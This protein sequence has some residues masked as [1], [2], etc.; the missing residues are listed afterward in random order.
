MKRRLFWIL[1]VV[2]IFLAG[3]VIRVF[4]QS[5]GQT[6]YL[7]VIFKMGTWTPTFTMTPTKTFTPTMT[8]TPTFTLTPTFTSTPT[9][10]I[11]PSRTS[12]LTS[13]FTP[14]SSPTITKTAS[15][16][17]VTSPPLWS[18]TAYINTDGGQVIYNLGCEKG[19]V[20]KNTTGKQDS[21]VL[22]DF[23]S[24]ATNNLDYGT[25]LFGIGFLRTTEIAMRA[26][27][28][29]QGYYVCSGTDHTSQLTLAIGTTNYGTWLT[30][31]NNA[32]DHGRAWATMVNNI[33]TWLVQNGYAGQITVVGA[34][35]IELTW[36][37]PT[38][39]KAWVNGYD[40]TN[41]FDVYDY[42]DMAGCPSRD[43][44]TSV[45]AISMD[46]GR[47]SGMWPM[48]SRRLILYL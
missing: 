22:L 4:S 23:G 45:C 42:G 14:S 16:T 39:S 38:Y 24:P 10:T 5:V 3:G 26:Q 34:S 29:A 1:L 21:V 40:E 37:S 46:Y 36:N 30:Q 48:E 7:P 18:R 13:T 2:I 9:N 19:T 8:F 27:L 43:R 6:L 20:D 12:T 44:P 28:Y 31:G 47:M 33:N 35:D 15:A 25:S 32:R 17:P 11:T 41:L